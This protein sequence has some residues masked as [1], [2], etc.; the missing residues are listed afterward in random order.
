MI[1]QG[2]A[3]ALEREAHS[4]AAPLY[5]LFL[6]GGRGE[7]FQSLDVPGTPYA[8]AVQDGRVVAAGAAATTDT[9]SQVATSLALEAGS[10]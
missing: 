10:I 3:D 9:L 1:V 6:L 7:L 2:D 4:S 5:D 8:I